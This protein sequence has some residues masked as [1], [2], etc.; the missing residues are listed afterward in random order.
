MITKT[1]HVLR[2]IKRALIVGYCWH[3]VPACIVH[4]SFRRLKLRAM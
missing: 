1:Q 3:I 2:A 4:A